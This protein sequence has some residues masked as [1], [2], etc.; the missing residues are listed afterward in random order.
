MQRIHYLILFFILLIHTAHSQNWA[1][2]KGP[3]GGTVT[4]LEYDAAGLKIYAIVN[5]NLFVT[6]NNGAKWDQLTLP[7]SYVEDILID[8]SNLV[9]VFNSSQ[10]FVSSD[11]GVNWTGKGSSIFIQRR[12]KKLPQPG[13]F[14]AYGDNSVQVT[15]DGG[16]T[17]K[18]ILS[19][20]DSP[21]SPILDMKIASNGNIFIINGAV[22][23]RKLPFPSTPTD[24]ANWNEAN[25]V[26]VLTANDNNI[27]MVIT[28]TDKIY[29]N[30]YSA[31]DSKTVFE[32]SIDYGTSWQPLP[33]TGYAG[34]LIVTRPL[35]SISPIGKIYL[36]DNSTSRQL[37]EY[38]DGAGTPWVSKTFPVSLMAN[39]E[40]KCVLWRN[41][42]Q[43]FAGGGI[44]GVYQTS[45]TAGSW[46][47]VS[48][49]MNFGYGAEVESMQSGRVI[50]VQG[51]QP[52][53]YYYSDNAGTPSEFWTFQSF[54]Y[55][56]KQLFKLPNNTLLINAGGYT[57]TSTDGLNWLS[58]VQYNF[59]DI[60]IVTQNDIYGFANDGT[61]WS[62]LNG[63]T[64]SAVST[65]GL[66]AN[67]QFLQA[68]RDDDGY[69][70][71]FRV[72]YPGVVRE[73]WKINSTVTPWVATKITTVPFDGTNALFVMNNK[74]YV[75]STG[76]Y[77]SSDKATTWKSL[78]LSGVLIPLTQGTGGIAVSKEGSLLITQ[79]DGQTF[80]TL[81]MPTEDTWIREIAMDGAGDF[82]AAANNSPALKFTDDLILSPANLPPY[83]NFDWQPLSGGP[84][85][86]SL[87]QIVKNSAEE[88]FIVGDGS[89]YK[90]N[91]VAAQWNRLTLS[92]VK[93]VTFGASDKMYAVTNMWEFHTSVDGGLTFTKVSNFLATPHSIVRNTNGDIIVGTSS[94]IVRSVNDGVSFSSVVGSGAFWKITNS[95]NG[96]LLGINSSNNT[97]V[98]SIDNGVT[99]T[100][101]STGITLSSTVTLLSVSALD[102]G[103][104]V[105]V[106]SNNIYLSTDDALTWVSIYGNLGG[107]T[108]M[109]LNSRVSLTPT[110]ELSLSGNSGF[111]TS[112]NQGITWTRTTAVDPTN[113]S[114]YVFHNYVWSGTKVYGATSFGV[115][116]STDSGATFNDLS[117]GIDNVDVRYFRLINEK[118]FAIDFIKRK[119]IRSDDLGLSWNDLNVNG[120]QIFGLQRNAAGD[121]L[122]FG[123]GIY[124]S[125]DNGATW[126]TITAN[127]NYYNLST[128]DGSSFYEYNSTDGLI[129]SSDLITW[130][131][132]PSTGVA[133]SSPTSMANDALGNVF[134]CNQTANAVYKVAF[135][136]S[137]KLTFLSYPR[138]V[139]YKN[140]KTYIYDV[141]KGIFE[142]SNG[143][144]WIK[145]AAPRGNSLS[146][147]SLN[148]FFI[149]GSDGA[150]WLS[151]DQGTTWQNV[152]SANFASTFFT[153]VVVN[154]FNGFAY[155]SLLYK[156]LHKSNAIVIPNDN[157]KPIPTIL[158]P[159]DDATNVALNTK[160]SFS[161][162]EAAFPIIGKKIRLFI[163]GSPT[164]I[165]ELDV[166]AGVRADKIFT[167][168]LPAPLLYSTSYYLTME[169]GAYA[170]LFG[171]A[172]DGITTAT[173]WSFTTKALPIVNSVTPI[174]NS[175]D[176]A[177]NTTLQITFSEPMTGASGK[178]VGI[179]KVSSAATPIMTLAA[180]TGVSL[181]NTLTFTLTSLLEYG[182][183]Y[184]VKFDNNSFNSQDG[185]ILSTLNTNTTWQF[186]TKNAPVVSSTTPAHN[187]T[188]LPLNTTS[189]QINFSEPLTGANGKNMGL[190]KVSAPTIPVLNLAAN[191]GVASG[192]SLTYTLVSPL[193]YET[194]YFVKFDAASFTSAV[195]ASVSVLTGNTDWLFTTLDA[196]DITSPSI[197]FT[198][199][200]K[201]AGVT[202]SFA[203]N[204]TDNKGLALDKA[205][206]F[207]RALDSKTAFIELPMTNTGTGKSAVFNRE[208]SDA[209]YGDIG[210]IEFYF[211]VEDL[212]GLTKRSPLAD[213]TYYYSYLKSLS[214]TS[215]P[216]LLG[217]PPGGTVTSYRIISIPY[218]LTDNKVATIFKDELGEQDVN[219]WRLFT[220]GSGD[221]ANWLEF[222]K[223]F[224]T[225]ERG[226]GYWINVKNQTQ[227]TI[228]GASSPKNNT[229]EFFTMTLKS[230]WNQIGNPYTVPISWEETRLQN[231]NIGK[232]KIYKGG[233]GYENG[234][235]LKKFEGGFVF[236]TG[237]EITIK[238]RFK[239]ITSGGRTNTLNADLSKEE[240]M[241][242]LVL[243]QREATNTLAGI[244]MHP[245][246]L[247]TFDR[248]DDVTP[249]GLFKA[250]DISFDH[251]TGS[252][253]RL[254]VDVAPLQ[255]EYAWTFRVDSE[256]DGTATLQ[257]D[258][259]AFGDTHKELFLF[260]VAMQNLINM[261]DHPNYQFNSNVSSLFRIYFGENLKDKI[262]PDLL[263]LGDIY[264]NPVSSTATIP[265]TLPEKSANY[266]VL[267]EL[268]DMYG[269][270]IST[271]REG[272]LLPGFYTETWDSSFP[273]VANGIYLYRL[274]VKSAGQH[275]VLYKKIVLKR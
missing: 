199:S 236:L 55:P 34:N 127:G 259:T 174:H 265:F 86:G 72:Q 53:G 202:Q 248:Y 275:Q 183:Q 258:N 46:S 251:P 159:A 79:D 218:N 228:D 112:A 102:A 158:T 191:T 164:I 19:L 213:N 90:Y 185:G 111:F 3:S 188:N 62:S 232:L 113:S 74:V 143:T 93:D 122:A 155:G 78:G 136:V 130:T 128:A 118:L 220:Y 229:T 272:N 73:F 247:A 234:D 15:L 255:S 100:L 27:G 43:A 75:G 239:G 146:I 135:G 204:A 271:I 168:T 169:A 206:F 82:I 176:V 249:P 235:E 152:G 161:F 105:V 149:P 13:M 201:A 41:N 137:S 139:V 16:T 171:N 221:P 123:T 58:S 198:T 260:D 230:G 54:A 182:T 262:K 227:L 77:V 219:T 69:F 245:N 115:S 119:V 138:N 114:K 7:V 150:L 133:L 224:T 95:T 207:Y 33:V 1:A 18:K 117:Q 172:F 29:I 211:Q 103:K 246:A 141:D 44:D 151:R 210:G 180:N 196:P 157:T 51:V 24:L 200:D 59:N 186:T 65:T 106:T 192:N 187:S 215:A 32:S 26:T 4:D 23:I 177:L 64:W 92:Q 48:N 63:L 148:Y 179:Y 17:W 12:I 94:G 37:W 42:I 131:P 56:I 21:Y 31:V 189:L 226:K 170:D 190:Y 184:F 267:L 205:K 233:S 6:A 216:L 240:W 266:F 80:R 47:S 68:T 50:Y 195:G 250:F 237:A 203:I 28:A 154:E 52:N 71:A 147:A 8:G 11:G 144:T 270:K 165:A 209:W 125:S 60:V 162:N 101:A 88:L 61:I 104:L 269:K 124:K 84:F 244:G 175:T 252:P 273:E 9:G 264:P 225:F 238:V 156:R 173:T 134:I 30:R 208:I 214:G 145:K 14:V 57:H 274:A 67:G 98:R 231:P 194:Q 268:Y 193:E 153:D 99:W 116:L 257:W 45:N 25:W 36:F 256:Y 49:G 261:R 242:P 222:P 76:T 163:Q 89:L 22:G 121:I 212:A 109:H 91:S 197:A 142:T 39:Q 253:K 263:T 83:I 35:W 160:L 181:N 85:G 178:N 140:G 108:F 38:T 20:P 254:T 129:F 5:N 223:D 70:Y 166:N 120:A 97:L 167:F 2:L 132:V 217:L 10:V 126:T 107:Q 40:V 81:T 87:Q 66:P 243:N 96:T 110:N 241:L